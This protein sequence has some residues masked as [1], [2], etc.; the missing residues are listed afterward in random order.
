MH[1]TNEIIDAVS[2][3]YV[4]GTLR[5]KAAV[6]W[7]RLQEERADIN[8]HVTQ[9]EKLLAPMA[10]WL[11]ETPVPVSVWGHIEKELFKPAIPIKKYRGTRW[12]V[13]GFA[14]AA[15]LGL[16]LTLPFSLTEPTK[17]LMAEYSTAIA[18]LTSD[19]QN[20]QWQLSQISDDT[21]SIAVNTNWQQAPD[22]SLELW[23]IDA[24][25]TP[26]SL[27]LI[28]LDDDFAILKL[29]DSQ[30]SKLTG[31][32]LFAISNEPRGGSPTNSPTGPV[33]FTGKPHKS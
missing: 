10:H 30:R 14:M 31:V 24:N 21:L 26:H 1:L 13:I 17:P 23:A 3:Q 29:S 18:T 16:W 22:R 2:A 12:A 11:P 20:L 19:H 7:K 6:R 15:S 33:L 25:G 4:L 5:G 27:G 8:E 9:W 28:N 32:T